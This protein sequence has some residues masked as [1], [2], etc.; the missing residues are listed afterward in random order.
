MKRKSPSLFNATLFLSIVVFAI[1]G[2][3][4]YLQ[5]NRIFSPG[6]L[7]AQSKAGVTLG[8]FG[9]HADFESQC[10]TCH[11]PLD[12]TLA[13]ACLSCHE[14]VQT[15][16]TSQSGAH[17]RLPDPQTCRTC[18]HE[19]RGRDYDM[20]AAARKAYDHELT[21]FSLVRHQVDYQARPMQCT[22][23]HR[24]SDFA[25][26]AALCQDCHQQADAAFIEQHTRD[27][28]QPCLA[29]HDGLDTLAA[30]DH[31]QTAF[32]LEGKHADAQ[33]SDC[34]TDTAAHVAADARPG[35]TT[36]FQGLSADCNACHAEPDAHRG[37]FN[38]DCASCH[39]PQGWTP[40]LLDGQPFSHV[41]NAGFSLI[42]HRKNADGSP[43]TCNACH[44][45]NLDTFDTASCTT[46]HT[47]LDAAFMQP[48]LQQF[49]QNCTSCHDGVD[50]MRNFDHAN[51]FVLDGRHADIQCQACHKDQT[52]RGTPSECVQCHQEPEIHRGSFG[53]HCQSCHT[54]KAWTPAALRYHAFPLDHGRKAPSDCLTCH[55]TTYTEYTCYTCHEHQPAQIT[56]SHTQAGISLQD[57]PDCTRCHPTGLRNEVQTP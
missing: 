44:Q 42:R 56:Q 51:V 22:A 50:R 25:P 29:C 24:E 52:F 30:F 43:L 37:M 35:S 38:T 47:T 41:E 18:H 14:N 57:L 12:S 55:E 39:T 3:M 26:Q 17:G 46:C 27:F 6:P 32:P 4:F 15:Q 54:S 28:G 21:T 5:R 9:S 36:A 7:S 23:C 40:A 49:G 53:L 16:I 34:H 19:H 20:T 48:H 33:C 1:I 31:A 8:G 45:Q 10:D 2:A 13:A 11:R